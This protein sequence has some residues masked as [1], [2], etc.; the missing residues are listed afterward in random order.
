MLEKEMYGIVEKLATK[1]AWTPY[2]VDHQGHEQRAGR[3]CGT[4]PDA[5]RSAFADQLNLY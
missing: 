3:F 2:Q 5:R 4:S 1:K